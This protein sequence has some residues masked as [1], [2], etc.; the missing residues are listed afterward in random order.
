M[1][2]DPKLLREGYVTVHFEG[3]GLTDGFTIDPDQQYVMVESAAYFEAYR[4]ILEGLQQAS[5]NHRTEMLPV[6]KRYLVDCQLKT[7]IPTPQYLR[8]SDKQFSLK[9]VLDIKVGSGDVVITDPTS[10]PP[11]ENTCLD[12]SQLKAF[13]AALT[14]EVSIIQGPPGTGKTFI[15]LKIVEALL[16]NRRKSGNLLTGVQAILANRQRPSNLP[17]LVLCYTNHALDQ[18][19]EGIMAIKDKDVDVVRIGGRCK[20]M[21]LESCV[22]KAK[23]DRIREQR[24]LPRDLYKESSGLRKQIRSLQEMIVEAQKCIEITANGD[25]IYKLSYLGEYVDKNHLLQLIQDKPTER[26]KEIDIWL[27]LWY[28]EEEHLFAEEHNAG[29]MQEAH[30]EQDITHEEHIDSDSEYI[31]VDAEARLLEEERILEGEEFELRTNLSIVTNESN[32]QPNQE[33]K[34]ESEWSVIQI[35]HTERRR[36]I[37]KGLSNKPMSETEAKSVI[38]I[39]NLSVKTRWRLYLYWE[40]KLIRSKKE[41]I[42]TIARMYNQRC[43][44][45]AVCRQRIDAFVIRSADI[46]G[47]TTTGAAKYNHVLSSIC[48]RVV[49][50][51]EAAEVFEA[52]VFTSLTPSVQQLIMIG[53]HKQL[54]PKANCYKLEKKYDFCVSLFEKLAKNGF[55]FVTLEVQHRMRPEIASLIHPSIYDKLLNHDVVH[56]YGDVKGVGKNLFFIDHHVPEKVLHDKDRSHA[57]EHE[58]DFLAA[59]CNYLL[60]QGYLPSQITLLT[61]YRGQLLELRK[62]MKRNYYNG[63]RVAVVDDFQGEENDIIILS[64]V[65]SNSEGNIGFLSIQNRICVSLSRAKMGFYVIGNLSMLRDKDKTVWPMILAN[66]SH[67]QCTGR[68]LPLYCQNHPQTVV[69]ASSSKDFLKCPE[70]GCQQKCNARLECGHSCRRLCHPVDQ[71][72]KMTKCKQTCGKPLSCGHKCKYECWKCK[73]QCL[74]CSEVVVKRID[75]CGHEIPM[76]CSMDPS[77]YTCTVKEEKRLPCGHIGNVPCCKDVS[78]F[79]CKEPCGTLLDCEHRCFG[80][81]SQCRRGR[82]HIRC[83]S[84]CDRQLVCGHKCDFPCTPTCPPCME[85]CNNY[86]IH[87]QCQR[88]CYEPCVPCTE[89][90]EWQCRHF[91]CS[92]RCGELCDRPPCNKPCR[93]VLECGHPCI[94]LCGEKCPSKCRICNRDEVCEIFFGSEDEKDAR[95]IELEECKHIIEVTACDEWMALKDETGPT[96][97]QFKTCPKCKSQI[98][99]SLRYGNTIKQTLEDYECIKKKEMVNLTEDLEE[100]FRIVQAKVFK[101]HDVSS[102]HQLFGHLDRLLKHMEQYLQPSHEKQTAIP[103]YRVN[104]VNAQLTYIP[105]LVKMVEHLRPIRSAYSTRLDTKD[106]EDDVIA[107]TDF[108]S[109][110][111]LSDQQKSDIQC[112]IYRLMCYIRLLD[113]WCKV[114]VKGKGFSDVDKAMFTSHL[115][116]AQSSGLKCDGMKEEQYDEISTFISRMSE[117]YGVNGLTDAERIEIVKAIGLSKG[118]WFKCPN[119]HYYCIG[120]CG[121]ASQIGNCPECGERIG[122]QNHRLLEGNQLA[123]EMDGAHYAAWSE[124]ANLANFDL[125]HNFM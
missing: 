56:H 40:N 8:L 67:K 22:L 101:L 121:G 13:I 100:R 119:G 82:L 30:P 66:L 60:K 115:R 27:K 94:G 102:V 125:L 7:P 44:E 95:F 105:F 86:C 39:W 71:E 48:P 35:S 87:S 49:I 6:F 45:Y 124:G 92:R 109:Q 26:G 70:G 21:V 85:E 69:M 83:Q 50:I 104:N 88:K 84:R 18:F 89:P 107:L 14:Q 52:H 111:Y 59:L 112:E 74:P 80:D 32:V 41:R 114:Q 57:N 77:E 118:H 120:E 73:Q 75:T 62:K 28:A 61:T 3:D 19:L 38:D 53:D 58:A 1:K 36:R 46:I 97:V 4:H 108:V 113:L 63:V 2:R 23:I 54:Q 12:S 5:R 123:P 76:P 64:L 43:K 42:A 9:R 91:K 17:I 117:Q 78:T 93:K 29:S 68:A 116:R 16:A 34:K 72:H 55:P 122:G 33:K 106:I 110:A 99:K 47:M 24:L 10:W 20:S 11:C 98:R 65:R 25:K 15:G 51:E 103:P 90:C 81:C 31:A 79:V 96:E 37:R